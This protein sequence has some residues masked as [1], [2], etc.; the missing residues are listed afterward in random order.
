MIYDVIGDIHG[1]ADELRALLDKLGYVERHGAYSADGRK[2]VFVGDFIDRGPQ[3]RETLAIVRGMVIRD[4]AFAVIGNHEFNALCY[5]TPDGKGGFLRSHTAGGGKNTKQHEQTLRQI[6]GPFPEEW[7]MYLE[8]F[9]GLP[10]FLELS[11]LRVVHASWDPDA[12]QIVRGRSFFDPEFLLAAATK[13]TPEYRAVELLLKGPELLL[14]AGLLCR[15]KDGTE[16]PDMRIAWWNPKAP[17][18][19]RTYTDIAVPG[20]QGIPKDK[21]PPDFAAALPTYGAKEPPVIFGHYWLR[22][23][24]AEV[25]SRNAACLDYS[26]AKPGGM[27]VAYSWDGART[28]DNKNFTFVQRA[29]AKTPALATTAA[30]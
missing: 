13:E 21:L 24:K 29:E 2:A 20:A 5:H 10:F 22:S 27:L 12:I 4:A 3:I 28:L 18:K 15:D 8:W 9:R 30:E 6:V 11:P 14:P 1:H 26:V 7:R 17:R 23:D 16:R 19:Q 25:L